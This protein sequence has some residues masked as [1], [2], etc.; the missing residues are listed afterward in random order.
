MAGSSH[1]TATTAYPCYLPVL[2]EFS[3]SWPYET[4]RR[5][6]RRICAEN[7]A[8]VF[9]FLRVAIK[10]MKTDGSQR[11]NPFLCSMN[12]VLY[13]YLTLYHQLSLPGMGTLYLERI[14]ATPNASAGLI[15]SPRFGCRFD[16]AQD[17]PNPAL[18]PYLSSSLGLAES[19][20]KDAFTVFVQ[21]LGRS[22]GSPDGA[23]WAGLG[24]FRQ[25]EQ[26][27]IAFSPHEA[28]FKSLHTA[29]PAVRIVRTDST[30][31]IRVGEESFTNHEMAAQLQDREAVP[32]DAWWVAA[33]VMSAIALLII[34]YGHYRTGSWLFN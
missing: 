14:P 19:E 18:F 1:R 28:L 9:F 21:Q 16:P 7:K 27:R 31:P 3:R 5:E 13:R 22:A 24:Q 29:V 6:D 32:R 8:L 12:D 23:T 17:T 33:A 2:G 26:G 34:A 30:H 15:L 4:C 25:D 20:A 11:S 10:A